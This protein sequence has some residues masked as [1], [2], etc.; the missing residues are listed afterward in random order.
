VPEGDT[1]FRA[2]TRLRAA[3]V[4]KHLVALEVRRDTRG[5]RGPEPGTEI[6]AVDAAG[7]H[8]LMRFADG[9]VL[10]THMQMTGA[11]HIYG[12]GQR[13]RRPGHTARVVLRVDDGTTA[14]CFAAP[15]VELRRDGDARDRSSR[16]S[17]MVERL[18]PDLCESDVDLDAVIGH[19][20]LLEPDTELAA[21]L[22]DQRVA[23]GI[24]NVFKSEI[25]WAERVFPFTP[26]GDLDEATRRRIYETARFQLRSNLATARRTT[27]A[28][29]L[30]VY[31]KA[32]RRCPRCG[33]TISS[34]RDRAARSTYWC[35]RCQPEPPASGGG[36]RSEYGSIGPA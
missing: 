15:I 30:A 29:G 10:H 4:G 34:R 35:P 13:W 2:A 31:R 8:L 14:V 5:R 36:T 33:A 17:R 21:A 24:G 32:G 6:T 27:F 9:H 7:K 22:L 26:I 11:W 19:L 25:F 18:G 20:A 28:N 23:A 16:A 3:L 12:P 1:I